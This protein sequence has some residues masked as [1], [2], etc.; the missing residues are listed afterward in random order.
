MPAVKALEAVPTPQPMQRVFASARRSSSVADN[1]LCVAT[2]ADGSRGYGEAS[3]AGYVTG[4]T[5]ATV[6]ADIHV[7][8]DALRDAE[9]LH[10]RRWSAALLEALPDSHTARSAVEIALLDAMC[11]S[12]GIGLWEWFGGATRTVRT[13]LTISL[14]ELGEAR[15][16]ANEAAER[17]FRV[18][19][20]KVGGPDREEDFQRVSE[21]AAGAP[22]CSL[23]LDANQGFDVKGTL[24][25]LARVQDAGIHVELIE[26]PLPKDDWSGM[27]AVT[28]RCSV[29]VIADEMVIDAP[30]TARVAR[31]GA[32]HGVNIKVAKS[33]LLGAVEII[34][35]ARA[36]GLQLML[37]CMLESLPGIGASIHLAGGTGAFDY[38][39]LDSHML[40]GVEPT[41]LPFSQ[42]RDELTVPAGIAGLGWTPADHPAQ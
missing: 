18:L 1:V 3:P 28:A 38:L 25:F 20:I 19:K 10:W 29:P 34:A 42:E 40:L 15:E 31:E 7:A 33:G 5:A 24:D 35:V 26:Q 13:D 16:R 39:D 14:T 32:A 22:D 30:S 23:R 2:L 36:H 11:R 41:G 17:G 6:Q 21:V 8:A 27:A 37:G 4:E 12:L 9:V